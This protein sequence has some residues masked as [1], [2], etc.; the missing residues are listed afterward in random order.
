MSTP[1]HDSR[2]AAG[3]QPLAAVP[4][5]ALAA[6][7]L[8]AHLVASLITPY[9]LHRD[10]F[11]YLAMGRHLDLW[12]MDFPPGIA[13]LAEAVRGV[14]GDS[15]LAVRLVPAAAGTVLVV[16]AAL[17]AREMGGGRTAQSLAALCVV[18]NLLFMRAA[19]LFQPVVLDQVWW[20][21]VFLMLARV[22]RTGEPR[23]WV[24][25]GV[26]GG[27]GLLTKW[28]ILF[29]GFAVLVG[30]AAT[31]LRRSL[32]TPWPYVALGVALLIGHPSVTGQVA[33][34]WPL[35][36][37]MG[38]LREAQLGRI[39]F[40]EYAG[41]QVL[42]SPPGLVLALAGVV[43]LLASRAL[44]PFR[45]VGVACVAVWVLLLVLRGKPYYVGPIYVA[46]FA[47]GGVVLERVGRRRIRAALL[48]TSAALVAAYALAAL[49]L[50]MPILPPQPMAAYAA[51]L[52]VTAA[53]TTNRGTVL[54]LP[55]DYADMLGWEAQVRAVARVYDSL[56]P[57]ERREAVIL[58]GNYGRAG[59]LDWYGPRL[60]LPG[61]VCPCGTYWQFGPGEKPGQVVVS[62]GISSRYLREHFAAVTEV[63]TVREPWGVEEEQ[64]VVIRVAKG[65]R[66]TLREMWPTIVPNYQ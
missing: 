20:A 56:P 14:F 53:T 47:A 41:E 61:A 30:L 31:P 25:M 28:S 15:L 12:R 10:E 44:R 60:G 29:I 43:G 42:Y 63:A 33:L 27:L 32:L 18:C 58:A 54:P 49:P 24:L 57:E 6:A 38:G 36:L 9:G 7:T 55:Q 4:V 21:L 11:L 16:L 17:V 34:D 2:G 3:L 8:A 59:A 65:P 22:A 26:A 1:L 45:V 46:L 48:W 62:V 37:Q 64:E 51:K 50:G 5:A 39:G 66:R 23:W 19:S 13:L 35:R 40:A 52:G